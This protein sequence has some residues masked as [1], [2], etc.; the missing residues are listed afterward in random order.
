MA[1]AAAG[2]GHEVTIFFHMGGVGLLE[3]SR[4]T[5]SLASLVPLGVRLLACGTS[6]REWGIEDR[7]GLMEGSETSSLSELVELLDDCDRAVFLG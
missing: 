1:R 3:A 4:A 2:R 6:A 5:K 7:G